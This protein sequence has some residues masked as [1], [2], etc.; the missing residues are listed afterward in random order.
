MVTMRLLLCALLCPFLTHLPG[1]AFSQSAS[2][3]E[4]MGGGRLTYSSLGQPKSQG[5]EVSFDYPKSWTGIAGQRPNTLYQVTSDY[6]KGLEICNLLIRELPMPADYTPSQD[7]VKEFLGTLP[8]FVPAGG[9]FI[10]G[11]STNIDGQPSAWVHL[12]H[13]MSRAGLLIKTHW[14]MF[15]TYYDKKLIFFSCSVGDSNS[16]WESL[17]QKY[18]AFMPLFQQMASSII[19]HS[20]WK[21]VSQ[22]PSAPI[23]TPIDYDPFAV[24][25]EPEEKPTAGVLR[26]IGDTAIGLGQSAT[27]AAKTIPDL[28]A[29]AGIV[30]PD[31][32]SSEGARKASEVLE[33]FKSQALL[34][35]KAALQKRIAEADGGLAKFV[36]SISSYLANPRLALDMA[37]KNADS[38][39]EKLPTR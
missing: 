14:L 37:M 6:G 23:L 9:E 19:I 3:S 27:G 4:F 39:L 7:E 33:G 21:A 29:I 13:E 28:A 26:T 35:E 17:Q 38:P 11:G 32:G 20:R 34:D 31:N 2:W 8:Q 36:E 22:V 25:P 24:K 15:P 16:S 1:K 12:R 5:L 30:R 18:R 10:E